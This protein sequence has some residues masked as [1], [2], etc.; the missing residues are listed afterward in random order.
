MS[1]SAARLWAPGIYL[2]DLEA[3]ASGCSLRRSNLGFG[4]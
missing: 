2:L 4:M 3:I 1:A